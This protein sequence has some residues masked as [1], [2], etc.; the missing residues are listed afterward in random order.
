MDDSF[1]RLQK[2]IERRQTEI[3]TLGAHLGGRA[4]LNHWV[5]STS[6]VVLVLL[7]ALAATKATVDELLGPTASSSRLIYAG[8]GVA[9]A[10]I[11]GITAAFGF[12]QRAAQLTQLATETWSTLRTVDTE[13]RRN[14]ATSDAGDRSKAAL[15]LLDLQDANLSDIQARAARLGVNI[16]LDIPALL[17]PTVYS[18]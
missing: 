8:I 10:A 6:K 11:A 16:A 1:E 9:V 7:G 2:A 13:W 5:A 4:K 15:T 3:R 18:A 14:V 17:E 12:D